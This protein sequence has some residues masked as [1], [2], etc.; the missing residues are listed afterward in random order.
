MEARRS[1]ITG[2]TSKTI[3]PLSRGLNKGKIDSA[4]GFWSLLAGKIAI[5]KDGED[6]KERGDRL[7]PIAIRTLADRLKLIPDVEPGMWLSDEHEDIAITPDGAERSDKPTWAAEVKAMDSSLHLKYVI[8]DRKAKLLEGYKAI[9][10]VPNEY[11]HC[12]REQC[13]QYFVVCETLQTL[14]FILIDDRVAI[15]SLAFHYITIKREDVAEEIEAQK[16]IQLQALAEVDKLILE[17][18]GGE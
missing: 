6:P 10:L 3:K 4:V 9:D 11:S 15:D 5:Q 1:K 16:A 14:Y 8:A 18:T 12:Y 2:K 13:I 17:L 7:E